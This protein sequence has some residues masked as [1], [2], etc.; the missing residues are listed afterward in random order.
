MSAIKHISFDL[1]KT[2]IRPNP[3]FIKERASLFRNRFQ[4]KHL[5]IEQVAAVFRDTDGVCNAIN[6]ITGRNL[7]PQEMYLMI[8]DRLQVNLRIVDRQKLQEFQ[9]ETEALFNRFPPQLILPDTALLLQQLQAQGYTL[10]IL[11]N[12][13]FIKGELLRRVLRH[14][15]LDQYFQFQLYSDETGCSKPAPAMFAAMHAAAATLY[16]GSLLNGEILHI[17]DNAHADLG[18]ALQAGMQG[19]LINTCRQPLSKWLHAS[20]VYLA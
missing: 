2:L 16:Q 14:E 6:E 15:Q 1:W 13:G 9:E 3:A 10:N 17:G 11:C 19:S 8:L 18:G 12:T 20:G 5:P 7:H 4:L